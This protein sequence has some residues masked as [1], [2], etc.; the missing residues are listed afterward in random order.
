[1]T[2]MQRTLMAT[3]AAALIAACASTPPTPETMREAGA[4]FSAYETFGWHASGDDKPGQP[5]SIVDGYVRTAI[6]NELKGKGY[7]EAPAGTTPDLTI[8]YEGASAEKLKSKPFRIGSRSRQLREQR[9][10]LGRRR[11][12]Q[13]RGGQGGDAGRSCHRSGAGNRGLAGQYRA[14]AEQGRRA[15]V[16]RADRGGR[17]VA[18]VSGARHKSLNGLDRGRAAHPGLRP[19]DA[20]A[21]FAC[22]QRGDAGPRLPEAR[23]PA[24]DRRVQVARRGEQAAD[25]A[26]GCRGAR[27]RRRLDGQSCARRLDDR[28]QARHAGRDLRVRAYPSAQARED[29]GLA[30]ARERRPGR[31]APRRAGGAPRVGA[32]G[33]ALR[34]ARTTTR[35]SSPGRARSRSRSC[36]NSSRSRHNGSMP[37]SSPL[38]GEGSSA[39]SV[40]T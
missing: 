2:T 20:L 8:A 18:R 24:G 7:V 23:E 33:P 26:A 28:P 31:R 16:G 13:R 17:D 21:A 4:D 30:G 25:A 40:R 9:R 27:N 36:G 15:G 22:A 10:R 37:S 35:T 12:F 32:L 39:A 29:R 19:G 38:A 5:T 14:R 3:V 1:M 6:A 34:L 11:E